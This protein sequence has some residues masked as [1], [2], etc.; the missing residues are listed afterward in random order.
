MAVSGD[1]KYL[2]TGGSDKR[3]CI[4]ETAT[5]RHL[6]TFTQHR[7][8]VMVIPQLQKFLTIRVLHVVSLQTSST[9]QVPIAPSN[10]GR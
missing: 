1:G 7:G 8:P 3:I 10:Y 4:W 6:K 5:M 9:P 2:A